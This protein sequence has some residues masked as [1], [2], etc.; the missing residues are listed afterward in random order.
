MSLSAPALYGV[1]GASGCGRSLMPVARQWLQQQGVDT[2][3]LVFVDDHPQ[4]MAGDADGYCNGQPV[5]DYATFVQYPASRRQVLIGIANSRIRQQLAQR[6]HQDGI[7]PWTLQAGQAMV[8][9]AVQL[10]AGCTLSPF[11]TIG[12]NTRLGKQVQVNLYTYIEHDCVIGD[13]VTFAPRVSCNGNVHIG[14]HAY[15]GAGAL[16]RQGRPDRPLVIGAGAVIGMGAVVL[17][18]VPAGVTVVGNPARPLARSGSG[19]GL[20]SC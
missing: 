17:Q 3:Q 14:E 13:F 2:S 16:I 1:Y 9:D 7:D 19:S 10:G 12:A 5:V 6:L 18:D 11:V 15:I 20:A 8:M 4:T